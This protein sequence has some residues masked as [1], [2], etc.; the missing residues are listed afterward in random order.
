MGYW[1]FEDFLKKLSPMIR[2]EINA[3]TFNLVSGFVRLWIN[4][5]EKI[6]V[7]YFCN[8]IYLVSVTGLSSAEKLLANVRGNVGVI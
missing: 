1:N 2:T 5:I 6:E 8:Y 4:I 7:K 3:L